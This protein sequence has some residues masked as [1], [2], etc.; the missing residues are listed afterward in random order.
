MKKIQLFLLIVIFIPK[1]V[2]AETVPSQASV[3]IVTPLTITK[4]TELNFG[5]VE[6]PLTGSNRVV[7]RRN[8]QY[9]NNTEGTIGSYQTNALFR[10]SGEPNA[11]VNYVVISSQSTIPGVTFD[12]VIIPNSQNIN[13][14][15]NKNLRVGGRIFVSSTASPGTYNNGELSYTFSA[16]YE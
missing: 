16:E 6:I 5:K 7:V 12:R 3:E 10:L 8:G 1:I 4:E 11:A 14:N 13:N 9:N 2:F 15:G